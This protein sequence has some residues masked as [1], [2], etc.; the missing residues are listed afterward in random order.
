L[1]IADDGIFITS[2]E[3]HLLGARFRV[4]GPKLEP[5]WESPKVS[6]YTGAAVLVN[7]RLYLVTKAGLLK[8]VDWKTGRE[9]WYHR[10]F[11]TYGALIA[12]DG[13]LFVQSSTSGE[14]VVVD[15]TA[16]RYTELRRMQPFAGKGETF[17]APSLAHGRLY[18]R[19]Y[20]G[21]VVCLQ[22]G[23]PAR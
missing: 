17:T 1:V 7:Q 14:L 20:A 21:A 5:V 23:K 3:T 8:C 18:C 22:V 10:G 19:S 6:S 9:I 2:A 16:E 11:G 15:A 13:K 4:T 12:A